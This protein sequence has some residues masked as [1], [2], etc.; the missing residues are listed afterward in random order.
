[1]NKPSI[2]LATAVL[3]VACALALSACGDKNPP[4]ADKDGTARPAGAAPGVPVS[5]VT[6]TRR[7]LQ[8]TLTATGTVA[9]LS[10]VDVKSQLAG[11][12]SKVHVQEGQSVRAGDLLFTLDTRAD[13]AN[14]AKLRAQVA[15]SEAL[16]ADAQR[17]LA[18]ARDLLAKGF[19]SQGAVDS[20]QASVESLQAGLQSDKAALAQAQVAL[21]YGQVRAASAGRVGLVPVFAGSSVQANVTTLTTLTR[22]DPM[23]VSFSLPQ[24]ALPDLLALLKSGQAGVSATLP[25]SRQ[26]LDGRLHFVDSVVDAA[27]GTV[28]A[29]ARFDN[30]GQLLWP[31]AFVKIALPTRQLDGA[32]VVPVQAVIQNAR[33]SIVYLAVEGK[34]QQRQVKLL[35]VQGDDAAV[36]GIEAGDKVIVEGRQNLRPDSAISERKPDG[37]KPEGDKPGAASPA[38]SAK[39][40]L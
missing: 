8:L 13:E 11:V 16:L 37:G 20:N 2:P 24:S 31:G 14:V 36:T 9:P 33:G 10:A 26:T 22:M 38:P 18:R 15:R 3:A 6:A 4:A 1:M 32:V 21:S 39:A 7:D 23:D 28:K 17:Q 40:A 25:E 30:A 29:K 27:T 19:V 5:T 12:I 35:A 34:A